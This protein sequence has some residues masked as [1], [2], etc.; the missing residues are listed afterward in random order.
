MTTRQ[1][2]KCVCRFKAYTSQTQCT[3]TCMPT[4]FAV[5]TKRKTENIVSHQ[6]YHRTKTNSQLTIRAFVT[7]CCS[8][9]RIKNPWKSFN[10]F[11]LS[12]TASIWPEPPKMSHAIIVRY[13]RAIP[14]NNWVN[15]DPQQVTIEAALS[16]VEIEAIRWT[17]ISNGLRHI[18][19]PCVRVCVRATM[20]DNR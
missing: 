15:F 5:Q 18:D 9:H 1:I 8:L 11:F 16:T 12:K 20:D 17:W 7:N 19:K 13:T 10:S 6:K 2:N 3:L 14:R 4:F